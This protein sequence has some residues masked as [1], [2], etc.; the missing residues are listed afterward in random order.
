REAATALWPRPEDAAALA[1]VQADTPVPEEEDYGDGEAPGF[2]SSLRYVGQFAGTY[3]VCEAPDRRLVLL[4]QHAAHERLTFH[5]LREAWRRRE[6][7]GQPFLFPV[8]LDMGVAD[9]R[10]L[11][12][13]LEALRTLGFDLEPY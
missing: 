13:H 9:A 11:V 3:L 6:P 12:E 1:R 5:R 2:F 4:D 10:L 8:I 7:I